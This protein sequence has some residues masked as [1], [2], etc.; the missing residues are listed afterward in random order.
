VLIGISLLQINT[1][2]I[3]ANGFTPTVANLNMNKHEII[4]VLDPVSG[5]EVATKGYVDRSLAFAR[6]RY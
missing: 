4:N 1:S 6:V 5:C 2:N 3:L